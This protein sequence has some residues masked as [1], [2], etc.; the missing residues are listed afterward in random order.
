[1]SKTTRFASL[2][3]GIGLVVVFYAWLALRDSLI[4][5]VSTGIAIPIFL[6]GIAWLMLMGGVSLI[7]VASTVRRL[8]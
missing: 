8:Q 7:A 5:A 3:G 1:M 6:H 4:T 2:I